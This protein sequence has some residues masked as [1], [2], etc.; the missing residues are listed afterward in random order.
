MT[1][2]LLL[3]INILDLRFFASIQ[4]KNSFRT[5][6]ETV[7]VVKGEFHK[8]SPETSNRISMTSH[9]VVKKWWKQ[10]E[11]TAIRPLMLTS[12]HLKKKVVGSGCLRANWRMWLVS[13]LFRRH[14]WT[15]LTFAEKGVKV[16]HVSSPCKYLQLMEDVFLGK[17]GKL[18]RSEERDG[19]SCHVNIC[20]CC[21]LFFSLLSLSLP[22]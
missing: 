3:D 5:V 16:V 9:T 15:T 14:V 20:L 12:F 6:L 7:D 8:Y 18:S 22:F 10:R 13:F 19:V 1:I 4:C 2:D 17:T 21:V 11:V